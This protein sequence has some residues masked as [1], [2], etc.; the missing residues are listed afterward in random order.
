MLLRARIFLLLLTAQACFGHTPR[1][2]GPARTAAMTNP[3]SG[4]AILRGATLEFDFPAIARDNVG[5]A[6]IDDASQPAR[7]RYYWL[8]TAEY[9]GVRFPNNHLQQVG[10]SFD[11]PLNLTPTRPR[12]DS[13]FAAQRVQVSEAA[14]E[15]PMP[16]R[17]VQP[18]RT[19]SSLELLPVGDGVMW[20]VRIVIDGT[21]A[22][23]AF[24][25]THA[26][27]IALG[28]CQRD[29]SLSFVRV[30]LERR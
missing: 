26:D 18:E 29:R 25:A 5:C 3:A 28:W 16:L 20:R 24:L 22:V 10:V 4:R 13:A 27:S 12:L 1:G 2:A 23:G 6:L 19:Q 7:R 17:T 30:P 9:P 15:P 14:G 8:A 21:K 11:L